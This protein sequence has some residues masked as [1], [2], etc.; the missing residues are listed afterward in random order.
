MEARAGNHYWRLGTVNGEQNSGNRIYDPTTTS[1]FQYN[2]TSH[3]IYL[4][5]LTD[6]RPE[7][8]PHTIHICAAYLD[9]LQCSL[10][11]FTTA[12]LLY[13]RPQFFFSTTVVQFSS[14]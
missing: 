10:H 7:H 11:Q 14:D 4:V 9:G 8:P 2:W 5:T 12:E 6:R 13:P 3:D 1:V